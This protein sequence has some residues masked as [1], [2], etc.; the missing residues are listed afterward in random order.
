VQY[1]AEAA[2]KFT[3]P[4]VSAVAP[5]LIDAVSVTTLPETTVDTTLLPEVTARVVVV[6]VF[7]CAQALLHDPQIIVAKTP[8]IA[9]NLPSFRGRLKTRE[10]RMG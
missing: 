7:V 2:Q 10:D 9:D 4:V 3:C 5:A 1:F 8:A 6:A